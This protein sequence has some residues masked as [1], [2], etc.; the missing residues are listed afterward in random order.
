MAK[1]KTTEP[2]VPMMQR[3]FL[4]TN[5]KAFAEGNVLIHE[6][7]FPGDMS[8]RAAERKM[9]ASEAFKAALPEG[10]KDVTF[11][12]EFIE[13]LRKLPVSKFLELSEVVVPEDKETK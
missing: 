7:R 12:T 1:P 2:K 5:V 3:Q 11:E 9:R 8:D 10:T 13:E 4:Y 6:E